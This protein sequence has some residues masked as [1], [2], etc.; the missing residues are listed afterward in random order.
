MSTEASTPAD[1]E[2]RFLASDA[3]RVGR[4]GPLPQV[5]RVAV[6]VGD[7][8]ALSGLA[9]EPGTPPR[10]VALHGAG[11]NAHSFD[12]MLLALDAP[13]VALDLPGHGRSDWRADADYRPDHLADDIVTALETLAPE[14][15]VLLGHSLGGLT[16]AL[17]AAARPE[18]VRAL[19]IVDITPGVSPQGDAGAIAEFISGQRDF[20]SIAEIVE[21]AI[22]FG[23]GSDREALTRG[24]ALNTRHRPDGRLEWTHHFAHLDG[25]SPASDDPHPYAQIWAS[26]QTL[27]APPILIRASHG[28][29]DAAL[30]AEWA[31]QLPASR[32]ET[33]TGPHNLHEAA[34]RELAAALAQIIPGAAGSA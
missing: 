20:G 12:P 32:I 4:T 26:L 29:V 15:V 34:P 19:V 31:E 13:A 14:P 3:A 23:I 1:D 24:V 18:L 28:M 21:R 27:E 2:F 10:L 8:R 5:A 7:G 30:A 22:A 9:F 33:L 6:P 11:L 16:A 25:L 17:A